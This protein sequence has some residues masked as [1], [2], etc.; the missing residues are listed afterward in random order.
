MHALNGNGPSGTH[1]Q[2]A[3]ATRRNR[4]PAATR[5]ITRHKNVCLIDALRGLG[6]KVPYTKD[7]PF[8]AMA[9][10]NPMLSRFGQVLQRVAKS[11]VMGKGKYVLYRNGHFVGLEVLHEG[12]FLHVSCRR[13]LSLEVS[14]HTDI[15]IHQKQLPTLHL[16]VIEAVFQ[17]RSSTDLCASGDNVQDARAGMDANRALTTDVSATRAILTDEQQ[18][19]IA[20]HRAEALRRRNSRLHPVAP[21]PTLTE[22]QR[23]QID[24]NRAAAVRLRA[25]KRL[26]DATQESEDVVTQT[27][28]ASS[29]SNMTGLLLPQLP[30]AW[31]S[32]QLPA[33]PSSFVEYDVEAPQVSLLKTLYPHQGDA[34]L[35]FDSVT[36]TYFIDGTPSMGSVTGLLHRFIHPFEPDTIIDGMMNSGRWPRPGYLK[37]VLPEG[38]AS[39]LTQYADAETL[40]RALQA[41]VMDDA[42][43]C[44]LAHALI[45]CN[46]EVEDIVRGIALTA[47]EIKAKWKAGGSSAANQGTWMHLQFELYLNLCDVPHDTPE[48][49]LFLRYIGTLS[50]LKAYRTEWSIYGDEERLAGSIDFV[51]EDTN[52]DLVLFDWKRT[53]GLPDKYDNSYKHM[54]PRSSTFAI[55]AAGTISCS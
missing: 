28:I 25:A 17:L 15:D 30:V 20:A 42:Y 14:T 53:K 7:G 43:V 16:D 52:G 23:A 18:A 4:R 32:P 2:D 10:G 3:K 13:H 44:E 1:E 33:R 35:T 48:M 26:R 46:P 9:D 24:A 37:S 34:H 54:L 40:L 29:S 8:W 22:E 47:E 21:S 36:H 12:A 27:A 6:V 39:S 55:A 41:P 38:V 49:K 45:S 31:T 50:G 5:H 19:R 11:D 51:A